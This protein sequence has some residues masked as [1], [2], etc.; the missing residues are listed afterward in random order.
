MKFSFEERTD[1]EK[2]LKRQNKKATRGGESSGGPCGEMVS[3]GQYVCVCEREMRGWGASDGSAIKSA[4][5]GKNL[6][7]FKAEKL[8]T[9]SGELITQYV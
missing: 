2:G 5:T 7:A 9:F 8:Q 3:E 1:R 6:G 4:H